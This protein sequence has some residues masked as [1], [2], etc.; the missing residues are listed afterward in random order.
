MVVGGVAGFLGVLTVP[1]FAGGF[2]AMA[3]TIGA[4]LGLYIRERNQNVPENRRVM[5]P[6]HLKKWGI[7]QL[8]KVGIHIGGGDQVES[9]GGPP[10]RFVG[11]SRTGKRDD[12]RS[13]QVESSKGYMAAKELVYDAIQRR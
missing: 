11:K 10:I 3:A 12:S 6:D 5:T 7:R 13:A 1:M 9:G 8:A 2:I 4:P